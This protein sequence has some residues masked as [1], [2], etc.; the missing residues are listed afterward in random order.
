MKKLKK[1]PR[2]KATAQATESTNKNEITAGP[3]DL[4]SL[5]WMTSAPAI[6]LGMT[7]VV[8]TAAL[9]TA[10]EDTPPASVERLDL[11][12]VTATVQN[13]T[14]RPAETKKAVTAKASPSTPAAPKT[15]A[16]AS[17]NLAVASHAESVP[18]VTITGCLDNE[19]G[20]FRL[21]D[22]SGAEAPTARSWKSGFLKK[23][24]AQ[25]EVVD[26]VGTLNLRHYAGRRVGLT[27]TLVDRDMRARSVR[28]I[29]PCE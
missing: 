4:N 7:F 3:T 2:A 23:R 18:S 28:L 27:G 1:A 20:T 19:D 26:A 24:T 16:T 11:S 13:N 25:I 6:V 12:P 9:L 22:A 15:P 17:N 29:G 21:T 10:G 5:K 8:V 14:A